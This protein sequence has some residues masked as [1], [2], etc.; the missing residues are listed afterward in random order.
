MIHYWLVIGGCQLNYNYLLQLLIITTSIKSNSKQRKIEM[1][2]NKQIP[3][4]RERA[5]LGIYADTKAKFDNLVTM[6][7]CENR[8]INGKDAANITK[9]DVLKELIEAYEKVGI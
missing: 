1:A 3:V 4:A 6:L 8:K 5:S 9:D 2:I 7:N